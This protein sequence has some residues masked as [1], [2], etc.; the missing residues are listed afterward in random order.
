MTENTMRPAVDRRA[1][2]EAQ[3]RSLA[4]HDE[5]IAIA[6]RRI[7][8]DTVRV[9]KTTSSQPRRVEETLTHHRVEVE[10]VPINAYVDAAPPLRQEG[11]VTILSVV[12][13]VLVPEGRLLLREEVR[14]RR[15]EMTETHAETVILRREEATVERIPADA[16]S[17]PS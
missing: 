2:P 14:M 11:D 15:V 5:E 6:R 9:S 4:L 7:P 12:E 13:E 8:R 17:L 3:D 16:A 10:R 1:L